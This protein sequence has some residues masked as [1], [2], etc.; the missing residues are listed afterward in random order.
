M[1][2]SVVDLKWKSIGELLEEAAE[3]NGD[4]PLFIYGSERMSFTETNRKVNRT[5]NALRGLGVKKGDR[6]SVMLPNGFDFPVVWL[7]LAKLGAV[8]VPTNVGY[9]EHDLQYVLADSQASFMVIHQDYLSVLDKVR[10]KVKN[11]REVVVLGDSAGIY[12]TYSEIISGASDEFTVAD[13]SE[14]DLVNIQYTSGTTGFP[15]G[16]MLTHRY[17]LLLGQLAS[18]YA[19]IRPDDVN[20][21]AQPFYYMDPQWNTILCLI[22]GIPLVIMP[23]FSPSRFWQTVKDNN[24]TFFYLLGTMPFYLLKQEGNPDLEKNHRLRVVICSG[25]HPKFHRIFEERWNVPWREAFGMTET[26]VDLLVPI[27]DQ[28]S[29]GSGAMGKPVRTKEARVVDAEGKDVPDGEIGELVIR[30][31]PMMLGYWNKPDETAMVMRGGW[32]HTGDLAYRD[33]KGYFHWAG[34]LK[35]MVRRSGENISAI[36]VEEV[37]V[38]HDKVK[39]AA[40]V[41]VP[42]E[43][44]GEEVKAYIVL[45]EGENRETVPPEDIL[46]FARKKL[47]HF[48]VP[49][50][51]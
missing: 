27:D 16:C 20:L 31:E 8:M 32:F 21:T 10:S 40:V 43:L 22:G 38:Q 6:V 29:V 12:P 18:E 35:D 13:V 14:G 7:A 30:G 44:R 50:Y 47:A 24:V 11:L 3:S 1:E 51:L 4:K 49:R 41:P 2:K 5:A 23:R 25:I 34:R 45:K 42:D 37:L 46:E 26:G 33:P 36:E 9:Q 15:K 28:D 39:A 17:W 48:K 19:K